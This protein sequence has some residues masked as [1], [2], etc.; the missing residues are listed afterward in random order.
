MTP[1]IGTSDSS[2]HQPL[3]SVSCRRRVATAIDGMIIASA[4]MPPSVVLISDRTRLATRW[5]SANH[6]YSERRAVPSNVAYFWKQV[7]TDSMRV[8]TVPEKGGPIGRPGI[9]QEK[10]PHKLTEFHLSARATTSSV[11]ARDRL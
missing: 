9:V 7:C 8:M 4:K 5:N 10:G 6:Q 2:C 1:T 3:R 11:R